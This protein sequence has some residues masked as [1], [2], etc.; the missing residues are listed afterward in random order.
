MM[1]N[2]RLSARVG[3]ADALNRFGARLRTAVETVALWHQ[4]ARQRRQ[5][6]A[7]DDRLYRDI[8]VNPLDA[9]REAQ[10]PFWRA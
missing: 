9:Y 7:L 2:A 3:G 4:R 8:G 1:T 10:K 5:L 6:V